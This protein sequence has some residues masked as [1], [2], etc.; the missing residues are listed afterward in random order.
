MSNRMLEKGGPMP[1]SIGR[2]V[3]LYHDVRTLRLQ[4]EKEAAEIKAREAEIHEHILQHLTRGDEQGAVGLRYMA[5]RVEKDA[6]RFGTPQPDDMSPGAMA[7]GW[8]AFTSW[9]LKHDAFH[10]LQKR[11]NETSCKIM[12]ATEGRVP[13]GVERLI[14]P[15]LSITKV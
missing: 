15:N 9:V 1:V 12:F 13:P 4:M 2:C 11:L 6:F 7:G 8:G 3:D 10:F 14:V 5:K